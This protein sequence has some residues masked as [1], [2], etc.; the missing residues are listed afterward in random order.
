V[1][2]VH[3]TWLPRFVV[4]ALAGGACFGGSGG[5]SAPAPTQPQPVNAPASV[6]DTAR[7]PAR[8]TAGAPAR[9]ADAGA[10][11]GAVAEGAK[12]A[13]A[14]PTV[15]I[16]RPGDVSGTL[17]TRRRSLASAGR[18]IP[19]DEVGYYVDILEA[20]L[21]QYR[22]VGMSIVRDEQRLTVQL[23]DPRLFDGGTTLLTEYDRT[24]ISVH[25]H[26]PSSAAAAADQRLSEQRAMALALQFVNRG[27]AIGRVLAVGYGGLATDAPKTAAE[28]QAG[29]GRIVLWLDPVRQ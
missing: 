26:V 25:V 24:L 22:G 18:A 3:R 13:A 6:R 16:A 1:R 4:L 15:V 27:V 9:D 10:T 11:R 19:A 12:P 5:G 21:R 28:E 23:S 29:I 8:T 7:P 17:E 20:R 2:I 14:A